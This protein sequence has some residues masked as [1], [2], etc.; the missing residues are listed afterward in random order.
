MDTL[1]KALTDIDPDGKRPARRVQRS[2]LRWGFS[3]HNSALLAMRLTA[4]GL[5]PRGIA[6]RSPETAD[7]WAVFQFLDRP[8]GLANVLDTMMARWSQ[9]AQKITNG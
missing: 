2:S 5:S 6:Q 7:L 3:N 9:G 8:R 4:W 1:A